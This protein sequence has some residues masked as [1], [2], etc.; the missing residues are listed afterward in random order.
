M[1]DLT[2]STLPLPAGMTLK[3]PTA[4]IATWFGAGLV[5]PA[6]G[7]IGSLAAI[8]FGYAL[9]AWL[10]PFGFAVAIGLFFIVATMAAQRY[11]KASGTADDQSIVVDEV[12]G[13]W[14]AAWPAGLNPWGWLL[15]FVLFRFFDIWKP[16]P[17]SLFDKRSRDGFDVVMDDVIA[18]L[19][20]L[21]GV[22]MLAF[23]T[24]D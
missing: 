20:A 19:Y 2:F 17:A 11:G 16:W 10:G 14:I 15:A 21:L 7:T 3:R 8:P 13:M 12:V 23:Y 22:S 18:G 6:P 4:F 1:R 24:F 5:R 9:A